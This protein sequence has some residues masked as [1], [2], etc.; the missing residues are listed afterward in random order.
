MGISHKHAPEGSPIFMELIIN[1]PKYGQFVVLYDEEDHEKISK[2][3][4][5]LSK[6]N[7]PKHPFY[8]RSHTGGYMHALVMGSSGVDHIS[9]DG[10]DNRK[11]N[12]RVG[13]QSQN[14]CNKDVFSKSKSQLKGVYFCKTSKMY[15]V[16]IGLE[17]KKYYGGCFTNKY[18][19]ALVA[20]ELIDLHHGE[21]GRKNVLTEEELLLSE[22]IVPAQL[23]GINTSGFRGVS[24]MK[25]SGK[26]LATICVEGRSI[27]LGTFLTKE[28]A[29]LAYNNAIIKYN[30]PLKYLNTIPS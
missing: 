20:N 3:K 21:F 25:K 30:R 16:E 8:V 15:N 1:S 24:E 28:D 22:Q 18:K 9:G 5:Y 26:W 13:T 4:W 6:G 29:A 11:S 27:G 17:G 14:L 2:H 19:A 23:R 10:T 7:K 12:L